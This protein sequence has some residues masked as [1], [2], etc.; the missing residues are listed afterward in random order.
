MTNLEIKE[1]RNDTEKA[2]KYFMKCL[3]YTLGPVELKDLMEEG[4]VKVI[5]VRGAADYDIS[6]IPGAIS[7][8]YESI[9]DNVEKL[10][11]DE[12]TVVCC[13]NQQCH[14]GAKACLKLADYGYPCMHLEGGFKTW[15]EEFGFATT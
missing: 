14:L 5:D 2:K 3:A 10:S 6:H 1:L 11:K 15:K 9:S 7:M 12:T 8:P 4:K 13:Y